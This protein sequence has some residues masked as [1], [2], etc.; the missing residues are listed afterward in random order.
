MKN[1]K[2]L[3]ILCY[4]LMGA[5][6]VVLLVISY[7]IFFKQEQGIN[8]GEKL[9]YTILFSLNGATS[10]EKSSVS[11][12]VTKSGC[13]VTMP[14]ATRTGGE[15]LG[16]NLNASD[17]EAKYKIGDTISISGNMNL[18]VISYK[19]NTVS[20]ELNNIDYLDKDTLVCNSYNKDSTCTVTLPSFN[21]VGYVNLGYSTSRNSLVGFIYPNEDYR[22]SKD[23]TLYPLYGTEE[24]M[25]VLSIG[26][27]YNYKKSFIE[28]ENGCP[29][30]IA[31]TYLQYIN[32]I[33]EEAPFLML[34]SKLSFVTDSSFDKIW[35]NGYVGMNYGPKNLRSLDIRCSTSVYNDYYG[36]MVHELSHSWDFYYST[37]MGANITSQNDVVNLYNK[38]IQLADRPFRDYSYSSI[39]EF[40]ADMVKYYYFK[41][42][43]PKSG[44]RD[45][46]YPSDIKETLEKYICIAT[47]DYD[48]SKCKGEV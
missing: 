30:N 42:L 32:D 28:V 39:Y 20:I 22:I 44:Y 16:F 19:T 21:K 24:H 3:D 6:L 31:N 12:E 10:L 37:K 14:V 43:V 48:E 34:G 4:T 27:V 5:I 38:Y 45:L 15:V 33:S 46:N 35:G 13:V 18:Y 11:C 23:V 41:Y 26:D 29:S 9:T 47:N 17:K 8:K 36:T 7:N 25:T 1:D 2:L 40:E